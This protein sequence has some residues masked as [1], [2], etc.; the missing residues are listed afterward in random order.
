[1]TE[2]EKKIAELNEQG[3]INGDSY[4][5]YE[6]IEGGMTIVVYTSLWSFEEYNY[7]MDGETIEA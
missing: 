2:M 5:V 6:N 4:E 1:M 3:Y 7:T